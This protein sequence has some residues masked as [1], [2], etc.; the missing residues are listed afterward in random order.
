MKEYLLRFGDEAITLRDKGDYLEIKNSKIAMAAVTRYISK[1]WDKEKKELYQAMLNRP[2]LFIENRLLGMKAVKDNVFEISDMSLLFDILMSSQK[3]TFYDYLGSD[4]NVQM[5]KLRD[6]PSGDLAI[7]VPVFN[8]SKSS[9]QI[10]ANYNTFIKSIQHPHVFV[11]EAVLGEGDFILP[12]S[13]SFIRVRG[14][15]NTIMWQKERLLNLALS[16]LPANF[17]DIAWIDADILFEN[18]NWVSECQAALKKF[19]FIQLFDTASGLGPD[20]SILNRFK[21]IC[22]KDAHGRAA[23]IK[24]GKEYGYHP[25]FAWAARREVLDKI[26]FFDKHIAGNGDCYIFFAIIGNLSCWH[27]QMVKSLVGYNYCFLKYRQKMKDLA[28]GSVSYISG[29]INHLYHGH[30]EGRNYVGRQQILI[31][32]GF[33]PVDHLKLTQEGLFEWN[34]EDPSV[35][36]MKQ[37]I[38]QYLNG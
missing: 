10:K 7:I 9:G 38:K 12:E 19:C 36:K 15:D 16:K 5:E 14:S 23:F 30:I 22:Q 31:D 2:T 6:A 34:L 21:S 26:G 4:V 29:N 24:D 33:D 11:I 8:A 32:N 35:E 28:D 18:E 27:L 37:E 25:G 20:G 1:E 13:K 3:N 17:T